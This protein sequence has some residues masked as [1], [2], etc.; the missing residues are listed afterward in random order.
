MSGWGGILCGSTVFQ[1]NQPIRSGYIHAQSTAGNVSA[2]TICYYI[3]C[4]R[5]RTYSNTLEMHKRKIPQALLQLLL[6]LESKMGKRKHFREKKEKSIQV[7]AWKWRLKRHI[8]SPRTY[9]HF[10]RQLMCICIS[11]RFS[12]LTGSRREQY[13]SSRTINTAYR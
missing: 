12:R 4:I 11:F 3:I 10:N 13:C 6:W 7:A 2:F 5:H 1:L 9:S 8:R